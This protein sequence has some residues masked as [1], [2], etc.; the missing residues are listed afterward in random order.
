MAS[1]AT[2]T[3]VPEHTLLVVGSA[4]SKRTVEEAGF[5]HEGYE[6]DRLVFINQG[7]TVVASKERDG[8]A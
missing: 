4:E 1:L 6:E 7:M 5:D 3:I 2:T 8:S